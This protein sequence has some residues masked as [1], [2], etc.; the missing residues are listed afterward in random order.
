VSLNVS[1]A[2]ERKAMGF[3]VGY[4]LSPFGCAQGRLSHVIN[5]G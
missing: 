1:I 2:G 5:D 4:A 3:Y